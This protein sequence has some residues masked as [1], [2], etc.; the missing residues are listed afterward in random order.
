M[1]IW[2]DR[3]TLDDISAW[4]EERR[5]QGDESGDYFVCAQSKSTLG[6]PLHRINIRH[7][8][9][10]ACRVLGEERLVIGQEEY[11]DEAQKQGKSYKKLLTVHH[12][13]HSF[14][15]HALAGG[16][17]LAEVRDAAGHSSIAT[18]SV[19]THVVGSDEEVGNLFDFAAPGD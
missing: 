8:F 6:Q 9:Q 1:P 19:Y 5:G 4:R 16:R 18:T 10:V 15:S 7:R 17:S 12:G 3:G 13:R 2:W 11:S 14:C